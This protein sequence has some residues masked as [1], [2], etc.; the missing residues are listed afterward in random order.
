MPGARVTC[1]AAVGYSYGCGA[2]GKPKVVA[3][4]MQK[5]LLRFVIYG[6][7]VKIYLFFNNLSIRMGIRL[8]NV[9][10]LTSGE[11]GGA[12]GGGQLPQPE[13]AARAQG[14]P[15]QGAVLRLGAR[16]APHRLLLAGGARTA[17]VWWQHLKKFL[18]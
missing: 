10:V 1:R 17:C 18:L 16:Q 13:A 11:R 15:G 2:T 9:C 8:V 4:L 6:L 12:A 5:M 3:D 7:S 14:A